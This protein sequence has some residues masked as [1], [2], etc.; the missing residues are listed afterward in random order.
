MGIQFQCKVTFQNPLQRPLSGCLI[1]VEGPGLDAPGVFRVGSVE[2]FSNISLYKLATASWRRVCVCVCAIMCV[3]ACVCVCV[4]VCMC[5]CIHAWVC[6]C[7][8]W[9]SNPMKGVCVRMCMCVH[10]YV[11]VFVVGSAVIS[12]LRYYEY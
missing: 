6:T 12:S 7:L 9:G 2:S 1:H 8:R 4:C 5:M 10:V 3:C 11:D